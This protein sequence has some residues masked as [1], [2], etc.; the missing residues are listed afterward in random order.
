MKFESNLSEKNTKT[1]VASKPF[2]LHG[3]TMQI[4][5]LSGDLVKIMVGRPGLTSVSVNVGMI[6]CTNE[7]GKSVEA[8]RRN[9]TRVHEWA[10]NEAR[11]H[12]IERLAIEAVH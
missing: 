6:S 10:S 1:V 8:E 11:R 2:A 9:M 3:I 4:P 7:R 5:Y 12:P